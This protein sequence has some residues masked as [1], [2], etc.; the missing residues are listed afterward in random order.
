LSYQKPKAP[1]PKSHTQKKGGG[2]TKKGGKHTKKAKSKSKK[3]KAKSKKHKKQKAK[4]KKPGGG[5]GRYVR[6]PSGT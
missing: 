6:M 1:S 3:Q 5:Q 2:G 4:G